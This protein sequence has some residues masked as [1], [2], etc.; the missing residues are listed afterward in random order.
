[1]RWKQCLATLAFLVLGC[2]D[3]SQ[4]APVSGQLT[5]DGKPLAD[6][7]I[8]FQPAPTGE[9]AGRTELGMGSYATTDAE[10][11]YTLRT[12]DTDA[13]GAVVGAHRVMISDMRTETD[14]DA[15]ATKAPPPRFPVR[16]SDGSLTFEVKPGGTDQANFEL[17][18]K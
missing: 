3:G 13:E 15:G 11:K 14:E 9:A 5:L 18:S 12:A 10:G 16:Y 8:S 17:S 4:I 1:M 2:S 6:A 7:R